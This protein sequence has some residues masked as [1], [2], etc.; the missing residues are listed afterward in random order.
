[1][2][3]ITIPKKLTKKGELVLVPRRDYE[4]LLKALKKQIFT[5]KLERDLEAAI[6]ETR[7][8][9]VYGPFN[10]VQELKASLRA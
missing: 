4:K 9:K 6:K 3:T 8:S 7:R 2:N 10:S 5:H 1:M